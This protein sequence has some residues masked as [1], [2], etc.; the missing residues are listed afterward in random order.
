VDVGLLAS[1]RNLAEV[2]G[3]AE[4]P[5]PDGPVPPSPLSALGGG[6]GASN[7]WAFGG[8]ATGSGHGLVVANP[9]FPWGGEARFWECHLTLPGELDAY[10]VALLGTPGVQMGFN[11]HVAW[12][13]TFS[14]GH[15]F[16]LCRLDLVDGRP[17][18]YRYGDEER[19]MVATEHRIAVRADDGSIGEATRTLW[20]SHHGPMVNLPLLGWGTEVGFTYRDT[21]LDN[22][23][24][25]AQFLG[26]ASARS[27]DEF[28]A[29]Y[30][31]VQALPWVN[32][33]AADRTGRA[34]YVDASSTPHLSDE[35][36]ARYR[37]R[38]ATDLV[39]ALLL[40]NRVALLDGSDPG[41]EWVDDPAARAPGLLAFERMPQLERRDFV[42]NAN[43]SHWLS[44][45]AAPLEG[46]SPLHG[47]ERVPQSL[48][49]RQNLRTAARLS[50][51]GQVTV[52]TALGAMLSNES[53]S[54]ELLCD[55]VVDRARAAGSVH[56]EGVDRDLTR[57]ADVLAAWDRRCDLASV[58]AALWREVMAGFEPKAL[59]DA[60][61][62]FAVPFDADDPVATP[63]GLA[64]APAEGP[65]PV[66]DAVA[67]AVAALE[68]AGVAID[69]PLGDVQ[70]AQRG[71]H[72][73]PVHGGYEGDGVLNI[74][75]PVGA[76]ASHS[77]EPGPAPLTPVPGR[78][79]TSGLAEG[80]YRCTYGTSFLMAV[81][82]TDDGPVGVG[83]LAYGQSGDGRAEHHV[84]GTR[85]Y[86][87][88]AV[89]PLRFTDADIEA[90]PALER[91][92][93]RS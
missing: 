34:W 17:T 85:A 77:L 58:G 86:A 14:R 82:L 5:G 68:V 9:H 79:A 80:G 40:E 60:G 28:Q 50:D 42:V 46:Y 35:A 36:L 89:R 23:G 71:P 72:R 26:M 16:V 24:I 25:F 62:L 38:V 27:M 29:T 8:D 66:L 93:L 78:E 75:A 32:T 76:L 3:R 90:D 6:A 49:T 10:G 91:R 67:R 52:D 64:P 59:L 81:E 30:R 43:D 47:F 48:R 22:H 31:E 12:A 39:A 19:D 63:H 44:N 21:N 33:L 51:G 54:A 87:A 88:K 56:H 7:G 74:L 84:D 53:L 70:W 92:T 69:A 55:A 13:H 2:I 73:V 20:H 45:A 41:D 11:A 15:R 37:E 61:P 4:A 1:G 18:A 57:A 83:L 65:D